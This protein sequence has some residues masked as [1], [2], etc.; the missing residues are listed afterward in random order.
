MFSVCNSL[1]FHCFCVL[2]ANPP[3]DFCLEV[4]VNVPWLPSISVSF[5]SYYQKDFLNRRIMILLF[6]LLINGIVLFFLSCLLLL[7]SLLLLLQVTV[8]Q[9]VLKLY[10]YH[11]VYILMM[12]M[13]IIIYHLWYMHRTIY[14]NYCVSRVDKPYKCEF[15]SDFL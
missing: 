6:L 15:I 9:K 11:R 14:L 1:I 7:L 10:Y 13:C 5:Y 3:R 8:F 2:S 12:V 4:K